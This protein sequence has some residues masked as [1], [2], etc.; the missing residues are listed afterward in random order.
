MFVGYDIQAKLLSF[1][2]DTMLHLSFLDIFTLSFYFLIW[3][4]IV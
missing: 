1:S 4:D 3:N 2:Y